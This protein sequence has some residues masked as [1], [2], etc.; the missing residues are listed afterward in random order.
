MGN[1]QWVNPECRH[2]LGIPW[3]SDAGGWAKIVRARNAKRAVLGVTI[4]GI[5]AL[6]VMRILLA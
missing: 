6:T 3:S 2:T 4:I 1:N 5:A